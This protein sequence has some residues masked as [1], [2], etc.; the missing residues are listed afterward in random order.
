MRDVKARLLRARVD[1]RDGELRSAFIGFDQHQQLAE[2]LAEIA[3][4]DLVDDEDILPVRVLDGSLTECIE[5]AILQAEAA[6]PAFEGA[7]TAHKVIVGIGL[8]E[9]D[10]LD[11]PVV[12]FLHQGI[13][14]LAGQESF[15][16]PRRSLQDQRL[17]GRQPLQD[18]PQFLFRQEDAGPDEVVQRVRPRWRFRFLVLAL[19]GS[20]LR[21]PAFQEPV[22]VLVPPVPDEI[23]QALGVL[24]EAVPGV[25]A[26]APD[27]F[28][29][30][31]E[32]PGLLAE[33]RIPFY[34]DGAAIGPVGYDRP[35]G[36]DRHARDGLLTGG[37]RQAGVLGG[38]GFDGDPIVDPHRED[39]IQ[40]PALVVVLPDAFLQE[41]RRLVGA[42]YQPVIDGAPGAITAILRFRYTAC[43]LVLRAP[44]CQG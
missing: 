26:Q 28:A 7:I 18:L 3:A 23:A 15:P 36:L 29:V 14:Q 5:D 31:V 43:A 11:P 34:F 17:L 9:L 19:H 38:N 40:V 44:G 8:V 41:A 30:G 39:V 33:V 13:G 37:E 22:I 10:H 27:R 24:A 35:D 20:R 16:D 25:Q 6:G 2:D 32:I 12:H 4:V 1:Q 21:L 42:A